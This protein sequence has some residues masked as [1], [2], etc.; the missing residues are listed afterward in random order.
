MKAIKTLKR[1]RD[2]LVNLLDCNRIRGVDTDLKISTKAV[3]EIVQALNLTLDD[4]EWITGRN[5]TDDECKENN[6]VFLVTVKLNDGN[7]VLADK[8]QWWGHQWVGYENAAVIAWKPL[9]RPF[10]GKYKCIGKAK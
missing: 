3:R 1:L 7:S 5:P 8:S 6:S 4:C 2:T 10:T 9:P